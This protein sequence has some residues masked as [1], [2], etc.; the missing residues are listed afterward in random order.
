M[1]GG[2]KL[3]SE[4]QNIASDDAIAVNVGET[5]ENMRDSNFFDFDIN[6]LGDDASV[7]S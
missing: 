4:K 5:L 3:M 7:S 6:G 2:Y 1:C